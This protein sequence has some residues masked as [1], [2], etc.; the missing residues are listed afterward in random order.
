MFFI[1][2]RLLNVTETFAENVPLEKGIRLLVAENIEIKAKSIA[3]E[4]FGDDFTYVANVTARNS[5]LTT[6]TKIK[7]SKNAIQYAQQQGSDRVI[8]IVYQNN[9]LFPVSFHKKI[10]K[11]NITTRGK[12]GDIILSGKFKEATIETVSG[13]IELIFSDKMKSKDRIYLPRCVF[14]DFTAN[15][16]SLTV[17]NIENT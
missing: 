17:Y 5:S 4:F 2:Y 7:I 6:Q 15:G 1:F 11:N 9:K 13:A 8:T 3:Q 12:V 10:L 14:W 16:M